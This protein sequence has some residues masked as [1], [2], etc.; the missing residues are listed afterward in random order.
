MTVKLINRLLQ[1]DRLSDIHEKADNGA[2]LNEKDAIRLYET[3]NLNLLGWLAN[4]VRKRKH[5]DKA[6]YIL[7][8]HINYS[9]ICVL[10]CQ[11]CSFAKKKHDAGAY[12]LSLEEMAQKAEQAK[13][14]GVTE[15]HLVGGMHPLWKFD[16][17]EAILRTLK[18]IVPQT[19]IKAFTAAEILHLARKDKKG[20]QDVLEGL[21]SAGMD[22][23][24]GGGA[25]IFSQRVRNLVCR[26]KET[27]AEWLDVHRIWHRMG[28]RSTCTMLYGHLETPAERVDHLRQLRALQDETGGFLAFVPL[29]FH[30]RNNRLSHLQEPTGS[31]NLRNLAVARLYLDNFNHI[32][33][34]WISHGL[35]L[36]QVSLDYGVDDLDGTI[37]EER[38]Y[39]TAGAQTP[40][41]QTADAMIRTIREAGRIP[42]QRDSLYREIAANRP[43]VAN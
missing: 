42:V 30:S 37:L 28:G 25:E 34:Y 38:I 16:R 36:A 17:Y 43:H 40:Q 29:P 33:C 14:H 7:N 12:E 10:A 9:N 19:H 3:H 39:H 35:K 22:S 15:I 5:G 27:A 13:R 41:R 21:R 6:Y 23:L 20:T 2:R 4:G 1:E 11:F 32:K 31:E 8:R 18:K 24:A 26:G